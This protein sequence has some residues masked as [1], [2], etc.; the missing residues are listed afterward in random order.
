MRSEI[1]MRTLKYLKLGLVGG[2]MLLGLGGCTISTTNRGWPGSYAP[3]GV[4]NAQDCVEFSFGQPSKYACKD[5][6][7]YTAWQLKELREKAA[8]GQVA[9]GY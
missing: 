1:M 6:K 4:Q 2:A 9:S 3:V 8:T 7:V 5:G